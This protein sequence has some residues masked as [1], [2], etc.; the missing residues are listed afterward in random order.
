MLNDAILENNANTPEVLSEKTAASSL[1]QSLNG[2]V[3][4]SSGQSKLNY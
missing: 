1:T 2:S 4:H 3:P